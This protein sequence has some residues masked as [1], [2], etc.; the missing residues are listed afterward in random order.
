MRLIP[1]CSVIL[2]LAGHSTR[3][4]EPTQTADLLL[5]APYRR[6]YVVMQR[7]P[8]WVSRGQATS[9]PVSRVA[10]GGRTYL[11][12]H[13][14]KPHDCAD[15]QL[16]IVFAA[17]GHAAWGLL[18]VRPDAAHPFLQSWL[19]SPDEEIQA[20]LLRNFAANNPPGP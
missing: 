14:C 5:E 16:D 2:L 9:T 6:A 4:A 3:A 18:H 8:D 10:S 15:N 19:G 11:L 20:L 7:F 1:A 12:G 13:L 17:D